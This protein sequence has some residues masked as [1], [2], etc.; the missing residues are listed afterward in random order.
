[1]NIEKIIAAAKLEKSLL[2]TA[3]LNENLAYWQ[4]E[5]NPELSI[6]AAKVAIYYYLLVLKN[7]DKAEKI[8]KDFGLVEELENCKK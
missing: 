4:R 3:K 6:G 8:A 1:M 2:E 7:Y 5:E